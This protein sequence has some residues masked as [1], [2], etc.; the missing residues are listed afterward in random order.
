MTTQPTFT[1]GGWDFNTVWGIS[2]A[3]NDG[4]PYLLWWYAPV[5]VI[6][7]IYHV[8]WF[9]PNDI[10][11]GTTLPDRQDNQDGLITWGA[12]PA[13]VSV[14]LSPFYSDYA[15]ANITLPQDIITPQDMIGPTG[16][17]D[18]TSEIGTLTGNPFYPLIK[19]VSDNTSIPV[20]L[21]W[22]IAASIIVLA[23][24]VVTYKYLPH[25]MIVAIEGGA[26]AAFFYGMGIFPFWVPLIFA[27]MALAIILGERSPTV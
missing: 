1:D 9:Q 10:I 15:P 13:G 14:V 5:W 21:C 20:R 4:Y 8:L 26:L 27:V 16:Q 23:A 11:D 2:P 7:D 12:N 17:Q 6:D 3:I 25:Q 19:A 22:I 24:M 18:R